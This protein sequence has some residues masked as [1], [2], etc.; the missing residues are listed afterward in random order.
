[1][2]SKVSSGKRRPS[3]LGLNVLTDSV[4]AIVHFVGSCSTLKFH[5]YTLTSVQDPPLLPLYRPQYLKD[6]NYILNIYYPTYEHELCWI[7]RL[8]V[9]F[10]DNL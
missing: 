6:R 5:E 1:M 4:T 10:I 2:R 7:W 8:Y 3:C 9:H